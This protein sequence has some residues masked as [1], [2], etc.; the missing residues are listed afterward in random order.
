VVGSVTGSDSISSLSISQLNSVI[1]NLKKLL[2]KTNRKK[3]RE[4]MEMGKRGVLSLP[5]QKQKELVNNLLLQ[6]AT[7]HNIA[8]R[9]KYLDGIC[10]RS[11]QK[12]YNQLNK[13]QVQ[14]VVEALKFIYKRPPRSA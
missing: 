5:T 13:Q 11:C 3:Y 9:H 14:K 8:D 7:K 1:E 4:N 12:G 10:M 2:Y 6:I